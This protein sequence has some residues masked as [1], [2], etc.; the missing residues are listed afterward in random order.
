MEYIG[1]G[2][3]AHSYYGG[4]RF[5]TERSIEKFNASPVQEVTVT[6][7]EAGGFDEYAML[8]LRLSEGLLFS[9]CEKFGT[10]REIIL[11][12]LKKIPSDCV[13]V[14]GNGISL[15]RKGFLLSNAV[16]GRVLG[17]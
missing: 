2:A 13:N 16:I 5:C 12:R 1:I 15:T 9:E 8:K 7:S 14:S 6:D 4:R 11:K 17:Y 10:D 3:A